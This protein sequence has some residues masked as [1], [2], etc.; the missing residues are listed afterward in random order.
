MIFGKRLGCVA[1]ESIPA[2]LGVDTIHEFVQC[3]RQLFVE[4]AQM[5]VIPAKLAYSLNLP[6]WRRFVGAAE[7]ALTLGKN[8]EEERHETTTDIQIQSNLNVLFTLYSIAR[9]YVED[10]VEEM[11]SPSS[12][13]ATKCPFHSKPDKGVLQYLTVKEKIDKEEVVNIITDL[14]LAAADTVCILIKVT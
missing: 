12:S 14:F 6:V 8:K 1:N 2:S 5:T 3:I 11:L 9:T 4:S 7:K 13:S 10:N